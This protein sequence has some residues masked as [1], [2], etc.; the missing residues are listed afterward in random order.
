MKKSKILLL[1]LS[2]LL[3]IGLLAACADDAGSN[4]QQT[5]AQDNDPTEGINGNGHDETPAKILPNLPEGLDLGGVQFRLLLEETEGHDWAVSGVMAE[6]ETGAPLNDAAFRRNEYVTNKLNF[7]IVYTTQPVYTLTSGDVRRSVQ[8]GTNDF[9]AVI[10]R[11]MEVA[12]LITTGSI[13]ELSHVP[14]LDFDKP[15]WDNNIMEQLSIDGRQFAMFGDFIVAANDAIR[16]LMFNK[17]LHRDLGLSNLYELV[18]EGR[19]TLDAFY[20]MSRGASADLT[21]DG[22]MGTEDRYGLLMQRGSV[23]C[24][25]IGTG[26]NTVSKNANDLPYVS[27][28]DERSLIALNRIHQIMAVPDL[29]IFDTAFPNE[30]ADLQIAF[31]NGQ[32]LF[33]GEVMQLA[34]RMRG[35]ELDFGVLPF[36]KLDEHQANYYSFVDSWCMNHIVIPVT[37]DNL[38]QTGQIL[39]ALSAESY[40]TVRPAYYDIMLT[41]QFVRDEESVMMLDIILEN[42]LVSLDEI[43][44]WGIFGA[45]SPALT[46]PSP[47]FVSVIER[48]MARTETMIERTVDAI[49]DLD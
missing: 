12:S 16:I 40:Y 20:E 28:G 10:I 43:F 22:T 35:T 13:I 32:G 39:E 24:F 7:E 29:V 37:N 27:I 45:I 25:M 8:A 38:E 6:A 17:Q 48:V 42:K 33:F 19:W 44:N 21:G 23:V 49:L 14:Y 30:W 31:E 46:A 26:V 41:G 36:P 47:D 15:W 3:T 4:N 1:A 11:Q 18:K 9:D 5:E 2:V 34:E